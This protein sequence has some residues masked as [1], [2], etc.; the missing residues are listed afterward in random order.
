MNKTITLIVFTETCIQQ[1]ALAQTSL[2]AR[3]HMKVFLTA[4]NEKEGAG[5][6]DRLNN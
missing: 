5:Q 4:T 1:L 6:T 3:Q 2:P